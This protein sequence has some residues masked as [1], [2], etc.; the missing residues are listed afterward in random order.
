MFGHT[1]R[2]KWNRNADGMIRSVSEAVE[3]ARSRGVEIPEYAAFFV[4]ELGWLHQA[5]A[6]CCTNVTLLV[7][8][9]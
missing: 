2:L 8:G 7:V 6:A 1:P 5:V 3:V 4:D 9:I